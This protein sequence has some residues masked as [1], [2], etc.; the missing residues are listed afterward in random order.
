MLFHFSLAGF[1]LYIPVFGVERPV[2][3]EMDRVRTEYEEDNMIRLPVTRVD[4]RKRKQQARALMGGGTTLRDEFREQFEDLERINRIRP[5]RGGTRGGA[6]GRAA[7][8]MNALDAFRKGKG[9]GSG[10]RGGGQGRDGGRGGGR[11]G[12]GNRGR[13]GGGRF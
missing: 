10:G 5:A 12:G 13:G 4:K 9:V 7:D 11:G 3:D 1:C 2:E 8:V 6:G